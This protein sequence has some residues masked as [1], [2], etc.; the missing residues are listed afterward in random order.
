MRKLCRRI[1]YNGRSIYTKLKPPATHIRTNVYTPLYKAYIRELKGE[2][3]YR[4]AN[5]I[6]EACSTLA[7]LANSFSLRK[8]KVLRLMVCPNQN[9][10][11][12]TLQ[13]K[14]PGWCIAVALLA[15]GRSISFYA[16]THALCMQTSTNPNSNPI[17]AQADPLNPLLLRKITKKKAAATAAGLKRNGQTEHHA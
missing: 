2:K 11:S 13:K 5:A 6:F 7:V 4:N 14:T 15:G 10:P 12:T 3:L 16:F 8:K 9:P 1:A 17:P